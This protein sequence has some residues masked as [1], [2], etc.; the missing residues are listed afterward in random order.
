[1]GL[2]FRVRNG[3]GRFPHAITTVTLD[4]QLQH[5]CRVGETMLGHDQDEPHGGVLCGPVCNYDVIFVWWCCCN[6][7]VDA[8]TQ[9][10][11]CGRNVVYPVC[12]HVYPTVFVLD[13]MGGPFAAHPAHTPQVLAA[14]IG[15]WVSLRCISTGQLHTSLVCA[16]TSGLSTQSSAGHL[17]LGELILKPASRLDAFSG[18]PSRT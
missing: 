4:P 18:Y 3:T 1:M 14:R 12:A 11:S 10:V 16:S 5:V 6:R 2:S 7:I 15:V 9:S 13:L 17:K 8:S